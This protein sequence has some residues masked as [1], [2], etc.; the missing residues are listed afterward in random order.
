MR[1]KS[2]LLF[3]AFAIISLGIVH[4][5]FSADSGAPASTVWQIDPVHSAIVWSISHNN[6]V[7]LVYGRFN[8]FHGTIVADA[9]NPENSSVEVAVDATS[10][11]TAVPARD[12]DLRSDKYFN[13]AQFPALSFKSTSVSAVAGHDGEYEVSGDLTV[14]GATKPL[15][16][17]IKHTATG[18]DR[19]GNGI[20][21]FTGSFSIKRS[22]FGMVTGIP[23]IGDEVT[24]MLAFECD[25]ILPNAPAA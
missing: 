15:T 10:L 8:T 16:L 6:G 24:I 1:K 18:K 4:P 7:G 22:D 12:D 2:S 23:G 14:L 21:G 13:V 11:D 25:E 19:K 20:A 9:A 5:A 17:T 3:I